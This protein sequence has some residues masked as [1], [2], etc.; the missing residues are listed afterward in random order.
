MTDKQAHHLYD[1]EGQ[2]THDRPW[3]FRTYAG[4]TN[5]WAS[6][7]L[8]RNNLAKGQTGLSIALDLPT[9]CGYSSD[10]DIARP[11]IGKVG[12]PINSLDDFRVLFD[13]IPIE[14]MNTSMTINGTSMWLLALYVALAEERGVPVSELR[15]T[16][17]NDLIK[18]YLARGTYIFPPED[19]IRL[20]VDMYEYCLHE[21]P[22]WNASN[23]CSYHLQEA[24]ATPVQELAFALATAITVLDAIKAR[25]CF[26]DEEFERCVGR[27][28]FFVNAGMRRSVARKSF[29]LTCSAASFHPPCR[30]CPAGS[31]QCSAAARRS[32]GTSTAR[33]VSRLSITHL[34]TV[35]KARRSP[36]ERIS[37]CRKVIDFV[38]TVTMEVSSRIASPAVSSARNSLCALTTAKDSRRPLRMSLAVRPISDWM[39]K[40]P[41]EQAAK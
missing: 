29:S 8:Y 39:A 30:A 9:Q 18:E 23:I 25:N 28:S 4:H 15:G 40:T 12:V 20:I 16:T 35:S 27:V 34:N 32:S 24:G 38:P 6:N 17:Q 14:Q 21:I 36:S 1:K 31:N 22:S 2:E 11:E 13:Q 37:R 41:S 10:D 3:I 5:V 33:R 19:S 26:S 7:E